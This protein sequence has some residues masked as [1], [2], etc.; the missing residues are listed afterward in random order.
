M[1]LPDGKALCSTPA[2]HTF[3]FLLR[4]DTGFFQERYFRKS[5]LNDFHAQ[6]HISLW[7]LAIHRPCLKGDGATKGGKGYDYG[8]GG[9]S[10]GFAGA[11]GAGGGYGGYGKGKGDSGG[12][13][14]SPATNSSCKAGNQ[15]SKRADTVKSK[16]L[17][18]E[19]ICSV[20]GG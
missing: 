14:T 13:K 20:R 9:N 3:F 17:Y 16:K 5:P 6:F 8:G 18:C 11:G 7:H 2:F 15:I 12:G 19:C 10:G 4:L 1:H